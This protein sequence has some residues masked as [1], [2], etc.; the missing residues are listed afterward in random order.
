MSPERGGGGGGAGSKAVSSARPPRSGCFPAG[1]RSDPRSLLASPSSA[2]LSPPVGLQTE[3]P[4]ASQ[5]GPGGAWEAPARHPSAAG[6]GRPWRRRGG[7]G[8]GP[9]GRGD[10]PGR[11]GATRRAAFGAR[12]WPERRAAAEG[13]AGRKEGCWFLPPGVAREEGS[14]GPGGCRYPSVWG[15]RFPGTD[16]ALRALAS[17]PQRLR[18]QRGL[19]CTGGH[20]PSPAFEGTLDQVEACAAGP[21]GSSEPSVTF[22]PFFG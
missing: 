8:G 16:R 20:S 9:V 13:E 2:R 17:R 4:P 6:F 10:L 5:V 7:V 3:P 19:S 21:S 11:G 12:W 1:R 15:S 18:C 22:S 14:L